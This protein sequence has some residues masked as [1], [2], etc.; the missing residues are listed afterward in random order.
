MSS[1]DICWPF[2]IHDV[3]HARYSELVGEALVGVLNKEGD[4]CLAGSSRL[5]PEH[6]DILAQEF[7][8][9]LWYKPSW[10]EEETI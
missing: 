7:D 4:Y 3:F 6:R 5:L 8:T 10:W 9:V 2:A 1:V